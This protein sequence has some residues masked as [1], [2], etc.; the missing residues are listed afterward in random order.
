VTQ[1]LYANTLH[2]NLPFFQR[3]ITGRLLDEGTGRSVFSIPGGLVV[4]LARNRKGQIEN[5][6]ESYIYRTIPAKHRYSLCPVIRQ[7]RDYLIMPEA[8]PLL[9]T[10]F[11]IDVVIAQNTSC[12]LYLQK[13]Y[14][15]NELDLIF[16]PNWGIYRDHCV[17]FDYG[18]T[19]IQSLYKK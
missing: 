6:N 3:R 4:K 1:Q 10:D 7:E 12:L 5:E 11:P 18:T 13:R 2:I 19:H 15:L 14:D 9:Q 16:P 17:L 8:L